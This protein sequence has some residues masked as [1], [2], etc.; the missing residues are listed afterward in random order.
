MRGLSNRLADEQ[1]RAPEQG[2]RSVRYSPVACCLRSQLTGWRVVCG[3]LPPCAL[4][5]GFLSSSGLIVCPASMA[6]RLA[7]SGR[8]YRQS[9]LNRETQSR[10]DAVLPFFS[11]RLRRGGPSACPT[12]RDSDEEAEA[13]GSR[14]LILYVPARFEAT[15]RPG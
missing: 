10:C 3:A 7:G 5:A 6:F 14:L 1:W 4:R 9:E 11:G 8:G 13:A 12:C 15:S 2:C